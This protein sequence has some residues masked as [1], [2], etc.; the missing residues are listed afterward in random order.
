[1]IKRVKVS[2]FTAFVG[3]LF[4]YALS[5]S[6]QPVEISIDEV[7]K[8]EGREVRINGV[9]SN[10]FITSSDNQIILLKGMDEKSKTELTIFSEKPIDVEIGDFVSAEGKVTRYKGKLEII[11]DGR[12]EIILRSSQNIS[13]FRL[14]NYPA[15][16][17]GREIN[18][19]GY[20]KSIDGNII[21]VE[22]HS[23]YISTIASPIDLDEV[24]KGDHVLVRG[25]FL[26][27]RRTFSYYILSSKVVK[28]A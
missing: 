15:N 27:D 16:Y 8:F 10:V 26:Y 22:N 4:L 23:Y 19:T 28:I 20:I 9:V 1:M 3:T 21:T 12:I 14:S 13:L 18:T 6:I 5:L 11:T 7:Q 17:V 25:L 24:S 2:L